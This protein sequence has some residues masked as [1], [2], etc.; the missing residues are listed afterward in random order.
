MFYVCHVETNVSLD[1]WHAC[2][3]TDVSFLTKKRKKKTDCSGS[4]HHRRQLFIEPKILCLCQSLPPQPYALEMSNRL[5]K[6]L[7]IASRQPR[8]G[9]EARG[10]WGRHLLTRDTLSLSA[11]GFF[12]WWPCWRL[13]WPRLRGD[14]PPLSHRRR[15]RRRPPWRRRG[16]SGGQSRC[17][18]RRCRLCRLCRA[19]R[20]SNRSVTLRAASS[21]HRTGTTSARSWMSVHLSILLPRPPPDWWTSPPRSRSRPRP[22]PLTPSPTLH[23]NK[24]WYY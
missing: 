18:V 4:C 2:T 14:H 9:G 19:G 20:C 7:V 22:V 21:S 1:F 23:V 16:R 6:G 3:H 17:R 13:R 24:I 12:W 8:R 5:L 11:L 10:R 15:Q